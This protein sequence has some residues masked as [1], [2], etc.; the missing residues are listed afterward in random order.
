MMSEFDEPVLQHALN[1]NLGIFNL[2]EGKS[3]VE[4][5]AEFLRGVY[6]HTCT[7][8]QR[9]VGSTEFATT[10]I[11]FWFT[12]PA[13]WTEKATAATVQAARLAGF[14]TQTNRP[15]DELFIVTEPEAAAMAVLTANPFHMPHSS[16]KVSENV[17]QLEVT[18]IVG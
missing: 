17:G 11:E 6:Q 13:I 1:S 5:V 15:Q 12:V 8:L 16:V 14:G 18:C 3:V 7:E 4:V 10:P 2:P 9:V